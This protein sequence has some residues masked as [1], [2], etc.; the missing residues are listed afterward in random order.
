MVEEGAKGFV[1]SSFLYDDLIVS[2]IDKFLAGV[3]AKRNNS[4][5]SFKF[6]LLRVYGRKHFLKAEPNHS[7]LRCFS[8]AVKHD[9]RIFERKAERLPAFMKHISHPAII[10]NSERHFSSSHLHDS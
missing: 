6:Q 1:N 7:H 3:V 10:Y 2:E 8:E 5:K 9:Q 4:S